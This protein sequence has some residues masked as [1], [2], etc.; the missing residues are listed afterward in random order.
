MFRQRLSQESATD[1]TARDDSECNP[2]DRISIVQVVIF[3][4]PSKPLCRR[5]R[6]GVRSFYIGTGDRRAQRLP[7]RSTVER[8][9]VLHVVD[10]QYVRVEYYCNLKALTTSTVVLVPVVG[11]VLR[12]YCTLS[13][14]RA[15][16]SF[17]L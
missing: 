16:R 5:I 11:K 7:V 10:F 3:S 4:E 8:V 6:T 17:A 1:M 9:L 2:N 12:D 14:T 15:W 13:S